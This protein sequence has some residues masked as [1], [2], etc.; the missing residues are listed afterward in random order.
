L[1]LP[2][3]ERRLPVGSWKKRADILG[4]I[5]RTIASCT[6]GKA[7]PYVILKNFE[8]WPLYCGFG[9]LYGQEKKL[10]YIQKI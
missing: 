2:E 1:Q 6:Y 5:T 9:P 7:E 3:F 8:F 4:N 10:P